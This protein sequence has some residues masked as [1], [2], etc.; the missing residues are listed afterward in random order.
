MQA[1][2]Q[3]SRPARD[4]YYTRA[5][6]LMTERGMDISKLARQMTPDWQQADIRAT[7]RS[8]VRGQR[9]GKPAPLPSME[10]VEALDRALTAEGELVA[11]WQ[12]AMMEDTAIRIRLTTTAPQTSTGN[13]DRSLRAAAGHDREDTTDRREFASLSLLA[14]ETLRRIDGTSSAVTLSELEDDLLEL[15]STFDRTPPPELIKETSGR[16]RQVETMLEGRLSIVDLHRATRLGGQLTYYLGRLAFAT[17][18]YR[19]AR[20]F[21]DLSERYTVETNDDVL[22]ASIAAL[23]SSIAFYTHRWDDAALIAAQARGTA[24]AYVAARLA[25]YEA[26]AQ[27]RRGRPAETATALQAMQA[28]I[29]KAT[30]PKPGSSPFSAGSAAMFSAVCL[31]SLGDGEHG[32]RYAREAIDSIEPGHHEERSHALL[33]LASSHLHRD[34]PDPSAAVAAAREAVAVPAGHLSSTIVSALGG[35]WRELQPWESDPD[36]CSLG[37]MI[38][39]LALALPA[40]RPHAP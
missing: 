3:H 16:W 10:T 4:R 1:D 40:G 11:L 27:A 7:V 5:Q 34:R 30:H 24:P 6:E 15:A 12:K 37:Q 8:A 28:G 25:A 19:D 38:S 31:V 22:L 13:L 17:G 32:E 23:R 33:A 20:R 2:D 9:A 18:H 35:V 39:D 36:V 14:I 21:T 26:R 29:P